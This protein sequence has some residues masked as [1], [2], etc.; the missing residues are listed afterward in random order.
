MNRDI[1]LS[2]YLMVSL[3]VALKTMF[4]ILVKIG[5]TIIQV[6]LRRYFVIHG[7]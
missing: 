2:M 6:D 1:S 7:W 3:G 4:A 5:E